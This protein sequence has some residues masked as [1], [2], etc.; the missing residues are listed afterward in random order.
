MYSLLVGVQ[1]SAATVEIN[2]EIPQRLE[3]DRPCDLAVLLPGYIP[4]EPCI[5]LQRNLFIPCLLLLYSHNQET[6]TA[7]MSII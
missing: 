2:V 7:E 3:I 1:T 4:K 5:T 6:E